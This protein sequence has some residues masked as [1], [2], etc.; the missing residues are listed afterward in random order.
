MILKV[1]H[2]HAGGVMPVQRQRMMT[3]MMKRQR[4]CLSSPSFPSGR[5]FSGSAGASAVAGLE[6]P[7]ELSGDSA[8]RYPNLLALPVVSQP[9]FPMRP[10]VIILRDQATIAAVEKVGYVGV[11]LRKRYPKGVTEGGVILD[12]PEI[13]TE[14][15]DLYT[16]GTFCK[17]QKI[18]SSPD[19]HDTRDEPTFVDDSETETT[20]TTPHAY[21]LMGKRRINLTSIDSVGPPIDVTVSHWDR[22]DYTSNDT[23]KAL[24][25]ELLTMT[26]ELSKES[27]M[28]RES[29]SWYPSRIDASDPFRLADFCASIVTHA[30]PEDL[31]AVLEEEDAE[32]RLH[33][34]LLLLFK[35]KEVAKVQQEIAAKIGQANSESHR[36]HFLRQQL[37]VIKGML[38]I[39]QKDKEAFLSSLRKQ[40]SEWPLVPNE[41]QLVI[42]KEMERF[43]SMEASSSEYTVSRTYL[44][45]LCSLPWGKMSPDNFDLHAARE[46][47]DRD[48]YG[49]D[50]VKDTIMEFIAV[51]KLKGSV[52]GKIIC[53]VG[54]P[55]VGKTS[56]AKSIASA[57]GREFF[58]FSVGGLTDTSEVRG[59]RRTYVGALPGKLI[60][61]LKLAGSMNP[62]V[63]IDEIDKIGQGV[64]GNPGHALLEVLDPNQNSSFVDQYLD[65]PVDM[66]NV[67]FVCTANTLET[68]PGPLLDRMEIFQLSGYD[69]PEKVAIAEQYLIPKSM[70][71]SGLITKNTEVPTAEESPK[72][73]VDVES[74]SPSAQYTRAEIVPESLA[75]DKSAIETLVRWYAREAGVR[76]LA[77]YI[78]KIT[79][80][81]AL[82]LVAEDEGT[83]LNDKSSRKSESW[84]V[85]EDNV[86]EYVGKPIFTS[87]RMYE[88]DP[89]P[90]GKRVLLS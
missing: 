52:Q 20:S 64:R 7:F 81:L 33:R 35:D 24:S 4:Q 9:I 86:A 22:L 44:D 87:D 53:L 78:D 54:P 80:K 28:F 57:L 14:S 45:W 26:R 43:D 66:S 63:L 15:S 60:Q 58:R 50:D 10:K 71:E 39:D 23:I 46:I 31:Q 16:V 42:D 61:G 59:H 3:M 8:P 21:W 2:C 79:R 90:N 25:N 65:V 72:D 76:N 89:L 32:M 34:A 82:Q 49:M 1:L 12:K 69:S 13:I 41:V 83:K 62:L 75:I 48:H 17:L 85:T 73:T 36:K 27:A 38:G 5:Y 67:L 74:T 70:T 11:F 6:V 68:I 40:L 29:M 30:T 88:K 51:G 18:N 55:G 37:D 19:S 56:V 47:L 84:N 77:N